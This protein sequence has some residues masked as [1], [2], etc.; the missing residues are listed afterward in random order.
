MEKK[1]MMAINGKRSR[2]TIQLFLKLMLMYGILT[3][4]EC[5]HAITTGFL[6]DDVLIRLGVLDKKMSN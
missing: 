3:Q 6:P 5:L 4:Q 1:M 2:I